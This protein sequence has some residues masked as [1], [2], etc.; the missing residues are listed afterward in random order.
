MCWWITY[1]FADVKNMFQIIHRD[2]AA[3]NV[4]VDHN[5]LC[6][7]ADFGMSRNVRDT[8]QI[9]EQRQSKVSAVTLPSDSDW[10]E[11]LTAMHFKPIWAINN[12]NTL[13]LK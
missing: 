6:K 13:S 3:R 11:M 8:G 2:L 9:Y 7:I 4:L 12:M 5:K 1:S 10:F